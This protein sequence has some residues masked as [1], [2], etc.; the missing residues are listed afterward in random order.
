MSKVTL[1]LY[2]ERLIRILILIFEPEKRDVP[3]W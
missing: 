3:E 2:L 1:V